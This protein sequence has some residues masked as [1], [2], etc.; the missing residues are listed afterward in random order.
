MVSCY[1]LSNYFFYSEIG[2][3]GVSSSSLMFCCMH[4]IKPALMLNRPT[5]LNMRRN[6]VNSDFNVNLPWC[7]GDNSNYSSRLIN[8]VTSTCISYTCYCVVF[9]INFQKK[10]PFNNHAWCIYIM[11]PIEPWFAN[12]SI[13]FYINEI[14]IG[15]TKLY[16]CLSW[17]F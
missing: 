8:L 2:L 15:D 3:I 14:V 7:K 16:G 9:F 6:A 5:T 11:S 4:S 17:G 1:E 12:S 13:Q 10:K